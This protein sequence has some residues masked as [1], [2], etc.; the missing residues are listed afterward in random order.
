MKK[1]PWAF[2]SYAFRPFFLL[3][4]IFAVLI[5]SVWVITLHGKGPSWITPDWHAHEMLVGFAMAAV[6]GFS[7]TA[8]A[9]WTGRPAIRGAELG[10][11]LL[12]WLAGRVAMLLDGRLPASLVTVLDMVFPLLL[13]LLLGREIIRGRSRRN[14]ILIAVIASMCVFN[15][16]YHVGAG[17]LLPNAERTAVLLLMHAVLLLVT[18]IAGRIVPSFTA[19]WLRMEGRDRMPSGGPRV[20]QALLVMVVLTG[21][22]GS[23]FPL[24]RVSAAMY[25]A[26]ALLHLFRLSRWRGLSTVSNPL[27]FVLH[28][29][30]AWLPAGY[31]L[32]G[33][34][35]MGWLPFTGAAL[36]ALT[37]GAIGSM[38]LAVMTRVALG[39]TGRPL[40]AATGTV[41]AYWL[42]TLAALVR[43][44][45][46]LL[47]PG[48][49]WTIDT[50]AAGWALAFFIFTW[51]YWPI[52]TRPR[53]QA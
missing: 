48:R 35:A 23:F 27:L 17:G 50:A 24:S 44:L 14:F 38:V 26:T 47:S 51:S 6:A 19:N 21:F 16:V 11:L 15:G 52:L 1:E 10:W 39:H 2:L 32:A 22:A 40:R 53:I 31:A 33:V 41:A 5:V 49:L 4:G 43:V 7:L 30:Y 8:V 18:L 34:V 45:G 3:N 9:T 28:V 12:S 37:M 25:F 13:V 42:L 36:H 46:P 20:D 29:A